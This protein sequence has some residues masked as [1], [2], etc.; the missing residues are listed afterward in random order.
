[1]TKNTASEDLKKKLPNIPKSSQ[2][3]FQAKRKLKYLHC[4]PIWKSKTSTSKHFWNL[5]L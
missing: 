3:S 1:M 5:K 2:N 4:S